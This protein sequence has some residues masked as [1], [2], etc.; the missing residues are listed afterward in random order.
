[1]N[2]ES[3]NEH[4]S[5]MVAI[6]HNIIILIVRMCSLTYKINESLIINVSVMFQLIGLHFS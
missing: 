5:P 1:M 6:L 3:I 4:L 2:P